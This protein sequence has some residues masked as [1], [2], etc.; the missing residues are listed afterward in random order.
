MSR[1]LVKRIGNS[2][3]RNKE[4]Y[5]LLGSFSRTSTTMFN[6]PFHKP[7]YQLY[8]IQVR[9]DCIPGHDL[10]APGN[11]AARCLLFPLLRWPRSRPGF[12]PS[13]MLGHDLK[14]QHIPRHTHTPVQTRKE[15]LTQ[16]PS[17]TR[18]QEIFITNSIRMHHFPPKQFA[19]GLISPH[20]PEISIPSASCQGWLA[21][22]GLDLPQ[23]LSIPEF[24]FSKPRSLPS[25]SIPSH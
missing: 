4:Y 12:K 20:Q 23:I 18:N 3:Q 7:N 15:T 16:A 9:I 8:G 21:P 5:R 11:Q 22:P 25:I 6:A 10:P 24:H 13:W 19:D 1:P 2:W 14:Y 17:L